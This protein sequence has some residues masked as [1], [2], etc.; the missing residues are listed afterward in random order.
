M[1]RQRCVLEAVAGGA[2]LARQLMERGFEA[3]NSRDVVDLVRAGSP[4]A[5]RLVRRSG[6][7][8]G[9]VLASAVNFFNPGVIVIGGDVARAHEQLLAGIRSA[10][11]QRSLPLATRHLEIVPSQLDDRA[12]VL[13]A[14]RMVI[15][16]TLRPE[17]IEEVMAGA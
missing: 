16:H 5:A 10:V 2:A 1:V 15:E 3:R 11:Y 7:L 9:E 17:A 13:G 12:G 6:Q 8:I 4:V 14:A